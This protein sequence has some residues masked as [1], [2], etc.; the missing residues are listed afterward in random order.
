[1][2]KAAFFDVDGTL[3]S[4]KTKTVPEGT[5]AALAALRQKGIKLI[6][7]TGRHIMEL[8]RLPVYDLSFD[9]YVTLN[10]QLCLNGDRTSYYETPF[11]APETAL[12]TDMFAKKEI[13]IML[14]ERD[15]MY[16]NF[17]TDGVRKTQ[18]E[19]SSPVA[20]VG[21]YAGGKLYQAIAYVGP[22]VSDALSRQLTEC[23]IT[24]W[25][26][27]AVDIISKGGGK[28]R[29]IQ[30]FLEQNGIRREETIAFGDGENDMEMLQFAGI[31]VAMGN[32]GDSVK[33][34]AD[35]VTSG[36]DEDGIFRALEAF[37]IL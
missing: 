35:Y 15:R 4:H 9:G 24:R 1:M 13:P 23:K 37:E 32:A 3:V 6:V 18:A 16:I 29:G 31:G 7:A 10:G 17:V 22:E 34:V 36:V 30:A 2:I 19:I 8:G 25:N 33:A 20:Q 27:N 5:R 21:E 26:G 14:I 12:L 11:K 28:V